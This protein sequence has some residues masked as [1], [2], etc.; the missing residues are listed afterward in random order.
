MTQLFHDAANFSETCSSCTPL[1]WVLGSGRFKRITPIAMGQQCLRKAAS[2]SFSLFFFFA[3][4][5]PLFNFEDLNPFHFYFLLKKKEKT[6]ESTVQVAT[7]LINLL[8]VFLVIQQSLRLK[9]LN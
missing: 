9:K 7:T 5:R 4:L 1:F 3:L 6:R 8:R 2:F